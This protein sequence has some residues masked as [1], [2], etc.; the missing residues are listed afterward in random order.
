MTLDVDPPAD[1]PIYVIQRAVEVRL[2][3]PL[4]AQTRSMPVVLPRGTYFYVT[5]TDTLIRQVV[6]GGPWSGRS[7]YTSSKLD[8]RVVSP[9]ELLAMQAGG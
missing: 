4:G 1:S 5:L 2:D 3:W 7:F 6:A 9:L 8:Y